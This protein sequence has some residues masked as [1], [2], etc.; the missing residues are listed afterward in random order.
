MLDIK[1]RSCESTDLSHIQK[2]VNDLFDLYPAE[3]GFRPDIKRTY[4]EFMRFP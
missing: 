1:F 3:E 2:L 4:T